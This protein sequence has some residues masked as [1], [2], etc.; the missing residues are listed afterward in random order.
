LASRASKTSCKRCRRTWAAADRSL[1]L[2]QP[3]RVSEM[4]LENLLSQLR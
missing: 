1:L 2:T 4:E 3:A